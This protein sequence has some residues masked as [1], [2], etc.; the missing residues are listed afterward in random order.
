MS[1][2]FQKLVH[3]ARQMVESDE[4]MGGPY[5]PAKRNPLP[6]IKIAAPIKAPAAASP[7]PH[8]PA[9]RAAGTTP[10]RSAAQAAAPTAPPPPMPDLPP[11]K[12][13]MSPEEKREALAALAGAGDCKRCPLCEHRTNFVFGEGDPAAQLVFVGEAPG[14]D[15][16]LQGR[17]FVGRAGQ[18]L[19]EM[20]TA[21]GLDRQ[22]VYICNILKCRPPNNRTPAPSEALACRGFL[23]RQLQI[24]AP[25]VI[26][27]L[28]NPATQNL[29][30]TVVGITK[31][32]GHWQKLPNAAPGLEGIAVMPTF[33]PS[34]VLRNY[35]PQTRTLVWSDLKQVMEALGLKGKAK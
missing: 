1:E 3:A 19:T 26:V 27:T 2:E 17:P 29:L 4:L 23:L 10:P 25:K 33:H 5:I 16:D 34:Y 24:I 31:L 20:I 12:P 14:E 6:P 22:Q 7:A 21:M 35:T 13:N 30:N 28:G 8:A 32:R 18:K 11:L 15:E 9:A